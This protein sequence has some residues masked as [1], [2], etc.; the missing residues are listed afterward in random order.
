[1]HEKSDF[2]II[3]IYVDY[4]ILGATIQNLCKSFFELMQGEFEMSIIG[5]LKYFLGLQITQ[6]KDGILIHQKKY[7]KDL[8][9][10][11]N[12]DKAKS[13]STPMHPSQVL[14]ADED[15]EKVFNKLYKGMIGSLLYLTAS[16]PNLQ[17]SVGIYARF[18]S[19]PNQSYLNVVKRILRYLVG[20]TNLGLQY[21]KDTARDIT[22]Y[23]DTDFARDRVERK[24]TS[25]CCYFFEKA[26]ITWLSKKQNTIALSIVEAEYVSA[27]NCCAQIL[28]IKHQLE[29]FNLRYTRIP[30]LCDNTSAINLAKNPIQH[31]RSK[32]IDIKHHFIKDHVQKRDIELSFENTE[33]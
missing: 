7:A 9:K 30:I 31:S 8:L 20:T 32:H 6:Q 10:K 19:N 29:D 11:F 33:D 18:Q 28:Q 26:L 24:S 3:Q 23:C 4:I 2:L 17:L 5:E 12:M 13:I 14:E 21:E 25:G 22:G 1:M 27:A 16:R 15:G